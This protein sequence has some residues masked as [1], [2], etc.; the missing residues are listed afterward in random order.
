MTRQPH[1]RLEMLSSPLYLAG[2]RELV[3]CVADRLGMSE[4]AC[5][6]LKL[7]VDEALCNV[8][9]HGYQ[10]QHDRPIWISI[11]PMHDASRGVGMRVVIE[12]EAR[13]VEPA[14]IRGRDLEDVKPGGLGVHIIA[15]LM[16]HVCYEKRDG[17]GMRL[18]L[19]KWSGPGANHAAKDQNSSTSCCK[20]T[21]P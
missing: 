21:K 16:D 9:R 7:S 10:N 17:S 14:E 5:C 11:E 13:Q 6:H 8:I 12:D 1:L 3:S 15:Q 18:T 4:D 20:R 19:V 2:A